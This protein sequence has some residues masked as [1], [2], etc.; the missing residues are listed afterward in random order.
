MWLPLVSKYSRGLRQRQAPTWADVI[1]RV[2]KLTK[3]ENWNKVEAFS[4]VAD[5]LTEFWVYGLNIYPLSIN[6]IKDKIKDIYE[7]PGSYKSHKKSIV[8]K[9]VA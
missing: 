8:K 1:G 9:E 2:L 6:R 4:L 7:G 5:E 3:E